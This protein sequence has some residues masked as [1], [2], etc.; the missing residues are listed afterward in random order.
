MPA[1]IRNHIYELVLVSESPIKATEHPRDAIP[2]LLQVCRQVRSEALPIFYSQNTFL[3]VVTDA[4]TAHLC[5]W[6]SSIG[7][8]S[9]RHLTNLAV[10][11]EGII[12]SFGHAADIDVVVLQA[13]MAL[14]K[15]LYRNSV[16]REAIGTFSDDVVAGKFEGQDE[17]DQAYAYIGEFHNSIFPDYLERAGYRDLSSLDPK[18]RYG[19]RDCNPYYAAPE[20]D[21]LEMAECSWRSTDRAIK[22]FKEKQTDERLQNYLASGQTHMNTR[23]MHMSETPISAFYCAPDASSTPEMSSG[24]LEWMEAQA[25]V[26]EESKGSEELTGPTKTANG[27]SSETADSSARANTRDSPPPAVPLTTTGAK[28]KRDTDEGADE[29]TAMERGNKRKKFE[30]RAEESGNEGIASKPMNS[31]RTRV[32]VKT[33]RGLIVRA[34]RRTRTGYTIS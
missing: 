3:H 32:Y 20:I 2:P 8:Q 21:L 15:T 33:R 11:C 12:R 24:F 10:C 1:E 22:A 7:P 17:V 30:G 4:N 5:L 6:L 31:T 16:S 26:Q 29:D 9:C 19:T 27:K 13:W 28:R 14:A 25:E 34:D 18:S 23:A